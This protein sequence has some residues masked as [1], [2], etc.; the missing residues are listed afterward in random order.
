MLLNASFA[1]ADYESRLPVQCRQASYSRG[2]IH[3]RELLPVKL[4]LTWNG[5]AWLAVFTCPLWMRWLTG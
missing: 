3:G 2:D 1:A 4:R 5:V